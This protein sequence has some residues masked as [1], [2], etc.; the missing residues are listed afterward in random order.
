MDFTTG[1][2]PSTFPPMFK[3]PQ[4]CPHPKISSLNP[5]QGHP[6]CHGWFVSESLGH[7]LPPSLNPGI[8]ASQFL[9]G[10]RWVSVSPVAEQARHHSPHLEAE[11]GGRVG[12]FWELLSSLRCPLLL[13]CPLQMGTSSPVSSFSFLQFWLLTQEL[14]LGLGH[15]WLTSTVPRKTPTEGVEM[16]EIS[17]P[18]AQVVPPCPCRNRWRPTYA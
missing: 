5:S 9:P 6:S 11:H 16:A 7:N 3:A 10:C 1:A 15:L 18:T 2:S 17:G 14:S 4:H 13:P 12:E 8:L